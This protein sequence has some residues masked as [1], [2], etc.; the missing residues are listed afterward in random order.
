MRAYFWS[1]DTIA[2]RFALTIVVTIFVAL[3]L[4]WL[5][6]EFA[7]VWGRPSALEEGLLDRANDIVQMVDAV[8]APERRALV[9]AVVNTTFH[10]AWFPVGSDVVRL[11]D[12]ASSP[13]VIEVLPISLTNGHP[14]RVL[15]FSSQ[16]QEM[17][18][19]VLH[20]VRADQENG[21][22]LA[23]KL[24]DGSWVSFT[25]PIRTWGLGPKSEF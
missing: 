5:L 23:A 24:N 21:Y 19:A 22:T 2:R 20:M 25:A 14:R 1:Q 8:P 9:D 17:Q 3:G 12:T 7:G 18:L 13:K 4:A 11:L 6:T 15:S 16:N 10:V